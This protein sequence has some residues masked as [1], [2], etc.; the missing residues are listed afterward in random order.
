[1]KLVARICGI[2]SVLFLGVCIV[3]CAS[4]SEKATPPAPKDK[5]RAKTEAKKTAEKKT[6]KP[7]VKKTEVKKKTQ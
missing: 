5:T 4:R 3:A 2:L 6:A 1:M 7:R